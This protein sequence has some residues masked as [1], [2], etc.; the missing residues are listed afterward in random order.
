MMNECVS[1]SGTFR[2]ESLLARLPVDFV[3]SWEFPPTF[4]FRF[5]ILV[6][7][8]LAPHQLERVVVEYARRR[9]A[10]R[11]LEATD[12]FAQ[13]AHRERVLRRS[14][15]PRVTELIQVGLKKKQRNEVVF[16]CSCKL[17]NK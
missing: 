1:C 7:A 16:T 13:T 14:S 8:S 9:E 2:G 15:F 10:E 4:T 5:D 17:E 11:C 3:S 6:A 12:V